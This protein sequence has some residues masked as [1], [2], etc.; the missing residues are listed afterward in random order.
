MAWKNAEDAAVDWSLAS[1]KSR[2]GPVR[3]RKRWNGSAAVDGEGGPPGSPRPADTCVRSASA[4]ESTAAY[5]SG[6]QA[7]S[8]AR[9]AAVASGLPDSVPAWYTGPTGASRD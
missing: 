3:P 1:A 7:R 5:T 9:P 8:V 2:T 6:V 4:N